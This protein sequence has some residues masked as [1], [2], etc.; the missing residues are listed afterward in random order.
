MNW[1]RE[2]YHIELSSKEWSSAVLRLPFVRSVALKEVPLSFKRDADLLICF[3]VSLSSVHYWNVTQSQRNDP[4][5]QN[6][7]DVSSRI[8]IQNVG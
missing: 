7:N 3:D 5:S 8:P 4:S 6:V 1:L 2:T